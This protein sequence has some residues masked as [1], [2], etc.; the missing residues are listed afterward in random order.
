[1]KKILLIHGWNYTNYSSTKCS[2]AWANRTNFVSELEKHFEVIKP[3]LPGFCGTADPGNPWNIDDFFQYVDKI[4]QQE[5]PD[6]LLGYSFGG[7]LALHWKYLTKDKNIKAILVSPAIIRQY[8]EKNPTNLQKVIKRIL[9]QKI[10]EQLRYLYL[11][12]VKKNPYYTN[13]T[14]VMRNTYRNIVGVDL[15]S[16]LIALSEPIVLIYGEKDTA[17]PAGLIRKT[18]EKSKTAHVLEII[19]NGGHD[20]A[21]SHT[22][23]L[24]SLILKNGGVIEN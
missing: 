2:D 11:S 15:R 4:I 10:V 13:A 18:V 19:A 12:I 7:A 23:E 17:T 1:M 6:M 8:A 9:P 5:K 14:P 21:N 3:N 16:E 22:S 24:V 20:I